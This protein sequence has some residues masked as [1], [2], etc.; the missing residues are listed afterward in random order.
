MPSLISSSKDFLL[1]RVKRLGIPFV[2]YCYFIGPYVYRGEIITRQS[3]YIESHPS[4][5]RA[6]LT[7]YL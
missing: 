4:H 2:V 5:S 7:S 3:Q 1:D 6:Y